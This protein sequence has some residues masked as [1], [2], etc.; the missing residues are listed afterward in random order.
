[1]NNKEIKKEEKDIHIII[2]TRP[3][4]ER[5][6][7]SKHLQGMK[8]LERKEVASHHIREI[9]MKLKKNGSLQSRSMYVEVVP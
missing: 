6:T 7:I 8:K 9:I 5:K 3:R 1:M 4:K 2:L